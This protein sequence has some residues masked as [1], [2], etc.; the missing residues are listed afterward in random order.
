MSVSLFTRFEILKWNV[1]EKG[2]DSYRKVKGIHVR[3][4]KDTYQ[5]GEGTPIRTNL[6][7]YQ[8]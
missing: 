4:K 1:Y 6:G 3:R 2:M 5:K 8:R 7:I